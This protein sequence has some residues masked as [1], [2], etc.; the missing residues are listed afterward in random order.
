MTDRKEW[1]ATSPSQIST[2][3]D[4]Q[5]KWYRASVLGER[6]PS[7]PAA[8]R[9]TRVHE[10]IE[11]WLMHGIRPTDGTALAMTRN[12]PAG[13]SVSPDH[14]ERAF[15][16]TPR[17]WPARVRGR[18]DLI[19]PD[20]NEIIDHKTTSQLSWAK[21]ETDLETD[22]QAVL[23]STVALSGG[24]GISF[25]EPLKFTLSYATTKG[26]V[27]TRVVSRHF[28][29]EQLNAPLERIM[30][31][32][33]DQKTVS[34][35]LK[36]E[37]VEPNYQSCKKYGQCH[38]YQDCQQ[39]QRQLIPVSEPSEASVS[40]FLRGIGK[41]KRE[42][43]KIEINSRETAPLQ[44]NLDHLG[45]A[46]HQLNPPDGLPDRAPLPED[47]RP[48]RKLP[49]FRWRDKSLS[50]MKAGELIEAIQELTALMSAQTYE[51]YVEHTR[52]I[53]NETMS[54][55]K[56][57]LGVIHKINYGIIEPPQNK[58]DQGEKVV[59]D[60]FKK[61]EKKFVEPETQQEPEQETQQEPEQETQQEPEQDLT[62]KS[63][64]T[65]IEETGEDQDHESYP[66]ELFEIPQET[67]PNIL[68]IDALCACPGKGSSADLLIE[69]DP[70]IKDIETR[71]G[72]PISLIQY[73]EGWKQLGARISAQ[74]W[75]FSSN[76][77]S[78]NSSHP[79]YRH[80]SHVLHTVSDITIKGT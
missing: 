12:L 59:Q 63:A 58:N 61:F 4:C 46:Y 76:I 80:C 34:S 30:K 20:Q 27:K 16:L 37:D 56:E 32:V 65:W 39:A 19:I 43:N 14:V 77:V 64:E 79:L 75:L 68:M 53:K 44:D 49:R 73:D 17:G 6:P 57:R 33:I 9:G 3:R 7:T 2:F 51:L 40:S 26:A 72:K 36:W 13:G 41:E 35:A 78:I 54:A 21:N 5:R 70:W 60:F 1:S 22:T 52:H 29:Q 55:N 18:I 8:E 11:Q 74:G 47:Q 45:S 67:Q 38:F 10:Q 25:D 31:D 71:H 23:Y 69:L 48:A 24:L 42:K 66:Q 15:D 50:A 28:T 62:P